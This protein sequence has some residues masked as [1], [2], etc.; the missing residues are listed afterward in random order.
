MQL[1]DIVAEVA[2]RVGEDAALF[3]LQ[4]QS[5]SA[6]GIF[7]MLL[8][9]VL[10]ALYVVWISPDG[11][12]AKDYV[13]AL[14]GLTSNPEAVIVELLAVFAV[15]HSGLAYLR[16]SGEKLIGA[17]AFRVIFA[18]ASLPLAVV[19]VVYFINHRY[20]GTPLWNIR[21]QPFVHE[22]VWISSFISFFFLYPSTF[23]LL[24]V[25]AVDEPKLH[26]WDTGVIRITR[27]PQALGQL[28]WCIAHTAWIGNSFMV[29]TSLALMVHHAFG[30]W[31]GDF[32]LRR[33]WGEDFEEV[34]QR[35]SIVP[36]QAIWEG[37]QQL[38]AD[39]YKEWLR[40]SYWAIV[41][42]T[43]GTYYAH[44]LMQRASYWLG[45]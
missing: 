20:S 16:P 17:R 18:L 10:A 34:K 8:V 36:F 35:T 41:A 4:D 24:E 33:K 11:G 37:R 40:P 31:H 14:K 29:T 44:P 26:L 13:Q 9:T 39:Y 2:A 19:A 30:C 32:R 3:N 23:N 38:P 28:I 43:V 45:W 25:A 42:F 7:T 5:V 27:H 1:P 12:L 15:A 21:G 6:W 22:A